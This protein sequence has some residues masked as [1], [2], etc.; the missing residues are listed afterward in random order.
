MNG[1]NTSTRG[2]NASTNGGNTSMRGGNAHRG[3]RTT[4]TN[5]NTNANANAITI[6]Q[7]NEVQA[8]GALT[9]QG[10]GSPRLYLAAGTVQITGNG[11]LMV[12]HNAQI[13]FTGAAPTAKSSTT[14]GVQM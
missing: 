2:G 6:G 11:T 9:A 10:N 13:S 1:G 14:D 5:E 12:S 4:N 7:L 3:Q 8:T